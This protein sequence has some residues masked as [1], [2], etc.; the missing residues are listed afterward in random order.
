VDTAEV[1]RFGAVPRA[2]PRQFDLMIRR[3]DVISTGCGPFAKGI[4]MRSKRT[5]VIHRK[6]RAPGYERN[7][8]E[9]LR[10]ASEFKPG[11]TAAR[12]CEISVRSGELDQL[13]SHWR[14]ATETERDQF[15]MWLRERRRKNF[16]RSYRI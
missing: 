15:E 1:A 2:T 11:Q 5:K 9:K 12:E 3:G 14:K 16:W 13:K 10:Q 7:H 4:R 6:R 8:I